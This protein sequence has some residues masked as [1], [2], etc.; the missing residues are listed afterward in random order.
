[1]KKIETK[2]ERTVIDTIVTYEAID[3]TIFNSSEECLKYETT[4]AAVIKA[5]YMSLIHAKTDEYDLFKG[6]S[7]HKI[8]IL[9]IN[10]EEDIKTVL[11][12]IQLTCNVDAARLKEDYLPILNKGLLSGEYVFLAWNYDEDWCWL[13]GTITSITEN[14]IKVC[15]KK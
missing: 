2:K 6:D 12:L 4:A 7:D 3:G 1:M 9:D 13:I 5:K 11:Q 15:T 8:D 14:I 10:T